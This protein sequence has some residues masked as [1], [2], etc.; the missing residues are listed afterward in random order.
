MGDLRASRQVSTA[1]AS[2][3]SPIDHG[4]AWVIA[5]SAGVAFFIGAGFVKAYTLVFEQLLLLFNE[6]ATATS[7]VSALH[8][9]VK[10][11]S[12]EYS[13]T[14]PHSSKACNITT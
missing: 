13:T 8:G 6:S 14:S 11:C 10:M 12:S 5:F 1:S 2:G 7:L 9:G 4:F 3:R